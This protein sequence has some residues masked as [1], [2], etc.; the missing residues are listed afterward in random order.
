MGGFLG[1]GG[2]SAKTDR[3]T[4]LSAQGG[5][6]NIFN[7]GLPTGQAQQAT[8]QT[9]LTSAK[10]TLGQAK[11]Y[12][13]SLMRPGRTVAAQQSAPAVQA[14]Q[15]Q[16]DAA[17]TAAGSQ[18][19]GR[20]GGTAAINREAGTTTAKGIDDIISQTLQTNRKEGAAGLTTVAGEQ[21]QIAQTELSNSLQLL[22]LSSDAVKSIMTNATAS[23]EESFK[24]NKSTQDQWMQTIGSLLELAGGV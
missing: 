6:Q 14:A 8:G 24:E 20:T 10:G 2:S 12:F 15:A 13:S 19:T 22:G 21:A 23:R 5:L 11:D 1:V 9:D 4:Q 7:Y 18:G 17:R 16:G 3:A